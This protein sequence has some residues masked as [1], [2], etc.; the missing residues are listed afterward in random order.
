MGKGITF[1]SGGY[2]K[3][4]T[5]VDIAKVKYFFDCVIMPKDR[6]TIYNTPEGWLVVPD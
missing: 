3:L 4:M 1:G 6:V 5:S 2:E